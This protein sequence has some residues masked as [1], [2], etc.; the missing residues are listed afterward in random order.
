MPRTARFPV[1]DLQRKRRAHQLI[2]IRFDQRIRIQ[3]GRLGQ[4]LHRPAVLPVVH[5]LQPVKRIQHARQAALRPPR[6]R[7]HTRHLAP[8]RRQERHDPARLTEVH[9]PEHHGL[10]SFLRHNHTP[11]RRTVRTLRPARRGDKRSPRRARHYHHHLTTPPK[12]KQTRTRFHARRT[13][14]EP[15]VRARPENTGLL[16][17]AHQI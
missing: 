7:P 3:Y 2:E 12:W 6:A 17:P 10:C 1:R 5:N 15:R 9:A 16:P 4:P 13:A 14:P 11:M 8:V